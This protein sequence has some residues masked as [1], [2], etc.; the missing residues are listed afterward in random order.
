MYYNGIYFEN[1]FTG[2]LIILKFLNA[3]KAKCLVSKNVA[4]IF[5]V[6]DGL[7]LGWTQ[8]FF[9]ASKNTPNNKISRLQRETNVLQIKMFRYAQDKISSKRYFQ[10]S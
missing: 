10:K 4:E 5:F 2:L 7:E 6:N 3:Y 9:F 8:I 1:T